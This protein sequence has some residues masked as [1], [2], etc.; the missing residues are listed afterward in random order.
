MKIPFGAR[1]PN[2]EESTLLQQVG[3][4]IDDTKT[5]RYYYLTLPQSVRIE[6][7]KHT[8]DFDKVNYI[9]RFNGVE[10]IS[11]NQ[12]TAM[13]DAYVYCNIHTSAVELALTKNEEF[14]QEQTSKPKLSDYQ[15]RLVGRLHQLEGVIF[16]GGASKGYARCIPAQLH[17]LIELKKENPQEHDAVI[18]SNLR[19]RQLVKMFPN[20]IDSKNLQA[21]YEHT[22]VGPFAA[23]SAASEDGDGPCC[24]M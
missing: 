13:Y 9:I 23:L 4:S 24:I 8:P 5:G 20:W 18:A 12:K 14:T 22:D 19:Y 21:Q 15:V 6:V 16:E 11:I 3:I 17:E 7:E 10:I 2:A 1:L